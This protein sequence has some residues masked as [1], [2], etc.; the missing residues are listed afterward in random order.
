MKLNLMLGILLVCF[1]ASSARVPKLRKSPEGIV[2]LGSL[3]WATP[4]LRGKCNILKP[5]TLRGLFKSVRLR[6]TA[7]IHLRKL[8][9]SRHI[10]FCPQPSYP[11]S[12]IRITL[13]HSHPYAGTTLDRQRIHH[14]EV[15][16][17]CVFLSSSPRTTG[18]RFSLDY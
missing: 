13:M 14:S 2:F 7:G 10:R 4:P 5:Y 12:A 3:A 11:A 16:C 8:M 15:V 9:N 6:R 17:L 1:S 18:E